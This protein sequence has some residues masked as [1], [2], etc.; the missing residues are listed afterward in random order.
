[1][2]L[3]SYPG[4]TNRD[5]KLVGTGISYSRSESH[6]ITPKEYQAQTGAILSPVLCHTALFL[7]ERLQLTPV[8]RGCT[9]SQTVLITPEH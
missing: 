3:D 2:S 9:G 6:T 1:M 4:P 7:L 5:A 8:L